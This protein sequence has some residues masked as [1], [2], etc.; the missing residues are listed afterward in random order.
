MANVSLGGTKKGTLASVSDKDM[1]SQVGFLDKGLL[2][3]Y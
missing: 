1:G 3:L 2:Q